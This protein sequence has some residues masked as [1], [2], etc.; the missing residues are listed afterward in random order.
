MLKGKD[1]GIKFNR[2]EMTKKSVVAIG[3]FDGMHKGH[4]L[5]I[6]K[7]LS[8]AR[9][10]NLRSVIIVLEKPVKKV[11]GLLTTYE[12]KIEKIK[13]SGADEIFVIG[14]PSEILSCCPE[15]FFDEFL[16]KMLNVSEIMCGIDFAFGKDGKGNIEWLKKKAKEK[17]IKINIVKP[18][19][20]I[21]S[22]YIRILIE[23]D[24]V[25]NA[26]SLLGRNY[27]FTGIPFKEKGEGKKLGFPTVNLHVNSDKLLPK[28][29]YI[30]LISQGERIYPSLTNIGIR[31]TFDRGN[32]IVPE[33][34]ILD[35]KGEWKKLQTKVMFLKKIRNEKKFASVDA[36]KIQIS[37]DL[38]AALRFFNY[39]KTK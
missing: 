25:K 1:F 2:C 34:Y 31:S 7:I 35:F 16:H 39:H 24:D 38:L 36:L 23:K 4:R 17:N 22:S 19:K 21:S 13:F 8:S 11:R 9:K 30:S 12:E 14:V 10:N 3:T 28:G 37:K 29:V 32:K 33:T 6:D 20:N 15:E 18:L 26:A 27:S 5:L